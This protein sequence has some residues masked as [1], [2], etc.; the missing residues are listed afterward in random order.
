MRM[1]SCRSATQK[2]AAEFGAPRG[3]ALRLLDAKSRIRDPPQAREDERGHE[4]EHNWAANWAEQPSRHQRLPGSTGSRTSR[5][6]PAM[7]PCARTVT[8]ASG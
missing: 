4:E 1:S 6:G 3:F 7:Y 5:A 2:V 8:I